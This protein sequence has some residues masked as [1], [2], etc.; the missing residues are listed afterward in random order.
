MV[1]RHPMQMKATHRDK[2]EQIE[3]STDKGLQKFRGRLAPDYEAEEAQRTRSEEFMGLKDSITNEVKRSQR[4][5]RRT[6]GSQQIMNMS[7]LQE[8]EMGI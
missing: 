1:H 4:V 7:R 8:P 2:S 5:E 3:A 6:S